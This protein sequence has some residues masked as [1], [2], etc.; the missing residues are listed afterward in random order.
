[1]QIRI[2]KHNEERSTKDY[3]HGLLE[4]PKNYRVLCII[5]TGYPAEKKRPH[6]DEVFEW[7]KVSHNHFDRSSWKI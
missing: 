6:G 5:G 7:S 3:V 1:M 4:I 2:R